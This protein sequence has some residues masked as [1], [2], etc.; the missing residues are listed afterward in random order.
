MV[1]STSTPKNGLRMP[2]STG[3]RLLFSLLFLLLMGN[4]QTNA[5]F[6]ISATATNY[7]QDFDALSSAGSWSNNS[8][9]TGWYAR[10]T[11]TS[12]ITTYGLNTGSTTT[13]GLYSY[14][15]AGTN[16]ASDRALGYATS[17]AFTGSSGSGRNYIGWRLV[18]NTGSAISSITVTWTGEQW[19]RDNTVAQSMNLSYQQGATV[20]DLLSGTWTSASSTFSS[21]NNTGAASALDGNAPG[22]RSAGISVTITV[23]IPAGEEIMLRW[24][25]LNDSG[26]DH[27]LALDDVT[28]NAAAA[29]APPTVTT[30]IVSSILTNGASSGGD[31][32]SDGG[33]S[34]TARGVAYGTS[35]NPDINGTIT[36]DGTGTGPFTSTLSGLSVNTQYYYRAYATNSAGTSYGTEDDFYTLANTPDAPSVGGPTSSSLNVSIGGGDGNPSTTTYAIREIGSGLYVQADGSRAASE[37]W[38]TATAW[39]TIA[40]TGLSASTLYSFDVKA[41]NGDNVETGFGTSAS[42]T[43]SAAGAQ[44]QTITFGPLSNVTYGDAPFAL[45]ATASSGLTVTYQSS[46]TNVAT[47]SGNTVTIVGAGS[48]TI[49]ASQP[50]DGVNWNAAPDVDQTL[51]VD[52]KALTVSGAV[53]Q[54]KDYDGNTNAVINGATLVGVVGIDDVTVSGGGTFASADAGTGIS[55]TA[56]LVL[57]G[58]DAGNYS[59]TQPTGLS[60]DINPAAQTITFGALAPKT[61]ADVP[62]VLTATASSGLTVTY[63][64]SNTNVATILGDVVTIVGAGSTTITA[65]QAGN[66]NYLPA[67]SVDQVQVVTVAPST[68]TYSFGSVAPGDANPTSGTPVANLNFSALSRANN[69]GTTVLLSTTSGS[70]GYTGASGSYNAGAAVDDGAFNSS[71]STYYEFTLTPAPAHQFSLSG[72]SFGTRSTSTGPQAYTLRSSLDGYSSDLATGSISNN[73]TWALKSNSLSFSS[74]FGTEVTFR[75]YVHSGVGNP[76][77][78][79]ANNR[80]DDLKLD[81]V[82]EAAPDCSGT[83][84]VGTANGTTTICEGSSTSLSLAGNDDINSAAG[85]SIQWFSST[86]NSNFSP[87][88]A[89]NETSLSTGNLTQPTYF[90]ATITCSVSGLSETSNTVTVTVDPNVNAGTLTGSASMCAGT[91]QLLTSNGDA[92]GTWNSSNPTVASVDGL[93]NVTAFAAGSTDITYSILS[94]CGAPSVATLTINVAE[95][96][97]PVVSG[98]VN[99]CA[100]LGNSEQVSYTANTPG[101]S[102]YTWTLPPNV[103]LISG[104]G[105]NTITVTFNAGFATQA[106]KQIRVRANSVCGASALTIYYLLTQFPTTPAPIV[107]STTD[108]CPSI[109]TNAPIVYTIPKVASATSYIWTA[110]AGTTTI[111]SINGAGPNDTTVSVVF[112]SGFTTSPITV[113]AVNDCGISGTRSLTITRANPSTPSLIAGPTNACEF[114]DPSASTAAYSIPQQPTVTTYTWTVPAGSLNLSG[115]GTNSISFNY[116]SGFNTG[117][118]SVV[119]SNGCGTSGPRSLSINTLSPAAPG[120]ID[121]IQTNVCPNREYTYTIAS[122]PANATSIQ[123]SVP[124]GANILSGQGT[125]SITVSYPA[126]A[127]SGTVSAIAQSNCGSSVAR[128]L[129]VKLPACPE[130][131]SFS[132]GSGIKPAGQVALDLQVYPN[133]TTSSFRV[134]V[135]G[136]A[137]DQATIRVMDLQGRELSRKIVMAGTMHSF[138]SDLKAGTYLVE[139]LQGGKRTVQKLVKL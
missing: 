78:G 13:A 31:V 3:Y 63:N 96:S 55:V 129:S 116:P 23:N 43:T 136:Q 89:G 1:M 59:L 38:Q 79:T 74:G 4:I 64:S 32:T 106:N 48:T 73:S 2:V 110:Q 125:T 14:G 51:T 53:A 133:P 118:V 27:H 10:T 134:Q 29:S 107:A 50:G 127:V 39:G 72:I 24:D 40:V 123:W 81:V 101:A 46:N 18:N 60:A 138:G 12:S 97:A 111:T 120:I 121:V 58:A 93:G 34:V 20:T 67:T 100:F 19:R 102:S 109:G 92:G 128:N 124:A 139:V 69:F 70:S 11:A 105:T 15:V 47:I 95:N 98:P 90:Y 66:G 9:L 16:P 117:T 132:K 8:T 44:N 104:A 30:T 84:E 36:S 42:G 62:F 49:T 94:G 76:A 21:P 25:D 82:V 57:G 33:A 68:V 88:G 5:Q 87:F 85:L 37:I 115:Q 7:T 80:I 6:S 22:N 56:N 28:V 137:N 131:G 35:A 99:V 45:T 26:N 126:T 17:N 130:G 54:N 86:D 61:T 83:P 41:R 122:L 65:S 113:T 91:L 75:L 52:P 71:T 114:I 119:A 112:A 77:L 135:Y 103:N 108:V